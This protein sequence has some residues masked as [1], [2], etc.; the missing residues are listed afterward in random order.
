MKCE[1]CGEPSGCGDY[2]EICQ[3]AEPIRDK[4]SSET[5]KICEKTLWDDDPIYE[6]C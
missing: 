6:E 1:I 3:C 2:H 5:C 4:H